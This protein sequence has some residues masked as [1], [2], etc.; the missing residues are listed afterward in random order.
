MFDIYVYDT[1][2]TSSVI[3]AELFAPLSNKV[4]LSQG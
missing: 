1:A 2:A 4:I 3:F